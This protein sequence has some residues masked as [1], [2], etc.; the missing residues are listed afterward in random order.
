[1]IKYSLYLKLYKMA[2]KCNTFDD[3]QIYVSKSQKE[4]DIPKEILV[5][6]SNIWHI[7]K[8]SPADFCGSNKTVDLEKLGK[9]LGINDRTI[10]NWVWDRKHIPDSIRLF[11]GYIFLIDE[12]IKKN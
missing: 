8:S 1:M 6:L 3:F 11:L 9:K 5:L 10:K 4:H 2:E 12:E 7:V